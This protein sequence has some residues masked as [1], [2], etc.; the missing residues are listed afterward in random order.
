MIRTRLFS[1]VLSSVSVLWGAVPP[2]EPPKPSPTPAKPTP[3]PEPSPAAVKS[4][5]PEADKKTS[6]PTTPTAVASPKRKSVEELTKG[7][8]RVTGL[9]EFYLDREKG[10]FYL[11]V[12]NDQIGPE[13]I[14]FH[15]TVDGVVQAGHNRGQY[16]DESIFKISRIFDRLEFTEQNTAFYFDPQSPLARAAK[17][18]TSHAVLASETIAATNSDGVLIAASGLFLKETLLMVKPSGGEASKTV[19]GKLSDTKSKLLN[20]HGY[21][22]NTTVT[23][24]YVYENATPPSD[25]DSKESRAEITDPRY[26]SIKVQ[27]SLIR[28]PENDFKPRFEDPRV[29]YFTTQVTDLTTTDVAPYRDVI[30]RWHLVKQKPGTAVSEPVQ[31]IVFWM[32]NTT[33]VELRDTIRLATL[34]WNEAFATAGFK[35]AIVVKQQPDNA[36]WDAGDINYNVLRWTSSPNPPFGG[37]GPSFVNPRTGQILGADIMLEYSFLTNRLRSEKIFTDL[38]LASAENGLD[39]NEDPRLCLDA[40]FAQQGIL[41][42]NAALRLRKGAVVEMKELSRQA[43][44]KLILHEVGHTLGLNHNFRASHLYDPVTI[45]KKEITSKTGLTGSV[46]DYMPANIAPDGTAQGEYYIT[47]PGPYDHWAIEFGYS[48]ALENPA[49]EQK[50]LDAICARSHQ[51]E[52]AFGNDADDMRRAGKGI[53]PRAMIYDMSG[54][55]IAYGVQ[56]CELVN[57]KL[58]ELLKKEPT[59]GDSWQS[60]TQAY[61]SLTRESADALVSMS[62]YIGGVYVERAVVG[63]APGKSPYTPVE[64]E[65]QRAALDAMARYAFAPNSWQLPADLAAHLQRQR[66]GFEFSREDEA[67]RLHDRVALLHKSLLDHLTHVETQRRIIDSALYGNKMPLGEVMNVLSKAVLDGDPAEGPDSVRQNLQSE[68]VDRLI[69]I[70]NN[71]TYLPAAQSVAFSE[72]ESIQKRLQAGNAPNKAFLLYKIRRGLDATP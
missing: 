26:V 28:M 41:F 31:P 4:A 18:N 61:S 42:G 23:V 12:R 1:V 7:M 38:G 6:P 8:H 44:T 9:F 11:F 69:K 5:T 68:Y 16:G 37:Y 36:K 64:K 25:H 34:K 35:D 43:L 46:M 50:R 20:I 67:P 70:V 53:D 48:E 56:R 63:Q 62:R 32:E 14:Y 65:R 22:D 24:E 52:L 47:K 13:F 51:P 21:P 27:H 40:G 30:H 71:S 58:A 72:L 17:A 57:K 49:D 45:H 33:P 2:S 60:L 66:R 55:P 39:P 29:G 10:G 59:P 19:L 3:S 54:D 15:H